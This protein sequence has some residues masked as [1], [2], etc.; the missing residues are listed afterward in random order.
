MGFPAWAKSFLTFDYH[1]EGLGTPIDEEV[2]AIDGA[3]LA[4]IDFEHLNDTT[5]HEAYFMYA[6]DNP[7]DE[8]SSRNTSAG[9]TLSGQNLLICTEVALTP[10]G[11]VIANLDNIAYQLIN[12]QWE[13]NTIA[14][15]AGNTLT[16]TNNIVGVDASGGALAIADL[17]KV[18]IIG[19]VADLSYLRIHLL[20]STLTI[21]GEGRLALLHPHMGEPFYFSINNITAAG[22]LNYMVFANINK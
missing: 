8:G 11:A 1:T 14:S 16:L 10:S 5:A 4:L 21:R 19:V 15:I 13:F 18:M 20:A 7:G 12:G 2:P 3:R 17:A 9:V 22:W 6:N